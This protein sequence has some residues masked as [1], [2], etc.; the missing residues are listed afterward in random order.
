MVP[1]TWK[2]YCRGSLRLS[3]TLPI[4]SYTVTV[5]LENCPASV[6]GLH[7]QTVFEHQPT[8]L[9]RP[10]VNITNLTWTL[11]IKTGSEMQ[12]NTSYS[13]Q[14]H[15][16]VQAR[17]SNLLSSQVASKGLQQQSSGQAT[18]FLIIDD[19]QQAGPSRP[20][21]FTLT[22]TKHFNPPSVASVSGKESQHNISGLS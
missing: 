10:V 1:P 18:S 8:V 12:V 22:P 6:A 17:S 14:R 4:L 3:V 9:G 20:L 15:R 16:C 2:P 11:P 7:L 19:Q 21:M 13:S 5:L